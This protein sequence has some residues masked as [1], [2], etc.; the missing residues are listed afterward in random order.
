[1]LFLG[2]VM[3]IKKNKRGMQLTI[4]TLV[5]IV[6]AIL[7]LV[8]LVVG[9]TMGWQQFWE[10]ITGYSSSDFDNIKSACDTKCVTNS[11]YDF[12]CVER[13]L[14]GET[15]F[16]TDGRFNIDCEINCEGIC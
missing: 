16:C 11:A 9:F 4:S 3:E 6:L 12:C 8:V 10:R 1:M 5:V 2:F 7:V 14:D 15:V 13:D